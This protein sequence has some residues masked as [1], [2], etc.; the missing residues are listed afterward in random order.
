MIQILQMYRKEP[1]QYQTPRRLEVLEAYLEATRRLVSCNV[2]DTCNDI[3]DY[4][5]LG[6]LGARCS[7]RRSGGRRITIHDSHM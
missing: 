2:S 6:A 3:A 5:A 7:V 4:D 1:L